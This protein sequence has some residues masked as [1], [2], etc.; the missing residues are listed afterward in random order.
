MEGLASSGM[1]MF[2]VIS[3][4]SVPYL[5]FFAFTKKH[6]FHMCIHTH[7]RTHIH[8]E[9]LEYQIIRRS[10]MVFRIKFVFQNI[11]FLYNKHKDRMNTIFSK[12]KQVE[13][14]KT[15]TKSPQ[16]PTSYPLSCLSFEFHQIYFI[17]QGEPS[18]QGEGVECTKLSVIYQK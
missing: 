14:D 6:V 2:I 13:I 9:F 7:T 10:I 17:F 12:N 5:Y 8:T 3:L 15:T 18:N 16:K 1:F 11:A 4:C